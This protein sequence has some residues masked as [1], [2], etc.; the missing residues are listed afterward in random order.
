MEPLRE[1]HFDDLNAAIE[2]AQS[3]LNTGYNRNGNWSLGQISPENESKACEFTRRANADSG[4]CE[5]S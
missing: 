3:L 2:E 1:L 5:A 4:S